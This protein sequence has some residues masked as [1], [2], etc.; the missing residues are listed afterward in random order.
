MVC[1]EVTAYEYRLYDFDNYE[2]FV[3]AIADNI[4]TLWIERG[5][6]WGD[7][8]PEM[9]QADWDYVTDVKGDTNERL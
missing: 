2:D 4:R 6:E 1:N 3:V 8:E 9:S 7:E 5:F